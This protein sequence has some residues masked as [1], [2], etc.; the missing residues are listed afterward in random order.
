MPCVDVA[1]SAIRSAIAHTSASARSG[2]KP[3]ARASKSGVS[4]QSWSSSLRERAEVKHDAA[5]VGRGDRLG[6]QEFAARRGH[7]AHRQI[8]VALAQHLDH[9]VAAVVDLGDDA[10]GFEAAKGEPRRAP[11]I[12][13]ASRPGWSDRRARGCAPPA[14][15]RRRRCRIRR[16]WRRTSPAGRRRRRSRHSRRRAARREPLALD[17]RAR[18]QR[19]RRLLDDLGEQFLP[20]DRAALVA[21]GDA[22]DERLGEMMDGCR[23]SSRA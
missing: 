6:A 10:V 7:L 23:R 12:G 9:H 5:L 21:R 20:A 15:C 16:P 3:A 22:L 17:Q 13:P 4:A 11:T 18:P 19:A 1:S 8:G 2:E 14:S